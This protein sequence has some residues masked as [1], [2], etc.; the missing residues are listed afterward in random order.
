MIKKPKLYFITDS[1]DLDNDTFLYKVEQACLGGIDMLQLRE[2][3]RSDRDFLELAK[4]VYDLSNKYN[5]PLLID[6]RIDIAMILGCGVHLG[7]NDIPI[8]YARKLMGSK[9][10][11]GAT[12]KTLEQ[13]QAA[14]NAGANY[15]GVGAIFPTTTKVVTIRTEV[16]TL[17]DI[18]ENVNIPVFAIGGLNKYN[19]DVLSGSPIYG[20]CVVSAIMKAEDPLDAVVQLKK[21]IGEIF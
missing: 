19:I 6:D 5:I 9:P 8:T 16:T 15:L 4:Q 3:N 14:E 11:I 20:I 17:N 1:T 18:C 21:S 10:I 13:A 12:A 7:Q 2:K